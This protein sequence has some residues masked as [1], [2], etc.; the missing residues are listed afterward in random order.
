MFFIYNGKGIIGEGAFTQI[1]LPD[2]I[3]GSMRRRFL[4]MDGI[5]NVYIG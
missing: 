1:L 5:L 4:F 2:Q 3:G